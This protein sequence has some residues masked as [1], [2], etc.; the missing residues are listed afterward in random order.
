[1]WLGS[2]GGAR[3]GSAGNDSLGSQN[4][5]G[6]GVLLNVLGPRITY[7]VNVHLNE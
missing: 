3:L 5:G 1:M 2:R 4:P 6:S 7:S